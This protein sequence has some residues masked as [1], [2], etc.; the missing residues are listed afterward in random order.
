MKL[1]EIFIALKVR[2]VLSKVPE[3]SALVNKYC[4]AVTFL[5]IYIREAHPNDGEWPKDVYHQIPMHKQLSER[6]EAAKLLQENG[7]AG[8][9]VVDT[10][11][12]L[13]CIKYGALPERLCLLNPDGKVCF[14]SQMGPWGYS[15]SELEN[16]VIKMC[17]KH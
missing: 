4:H 16:A 5:T 2:T 11:E 13:A 3:Y 15:L 14:M 9:L 1:P 10:M 17:E 12:D 7:L 8:N 6:I